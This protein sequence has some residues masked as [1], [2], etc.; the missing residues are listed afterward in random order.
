VP[1][2]TGWP[3][4]AYHYIISF[5]APFGANLSDYGMEAEYLFVNFGALLRE[6]GV[7]LTLAAAVITTLWRKYVRERDKDQHQT[8]GV[9]LL[10]ALH[11]TCWAL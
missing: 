4:G 7:A 6:S 10:A 3:N 1:V 11:K 8:T 9:R 5:I 2:N